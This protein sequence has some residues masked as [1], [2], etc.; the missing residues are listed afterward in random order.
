[1]HI[2]EANLLFGCCK[3]GTEAI[4][5]ILLDMSKIKDLELTPN[6][7]EKMYNLK[8][9][10]F[11]CSILHWNRVKLPEGLNF[12][13]DELRLLHWYEYPLESVPWSSCAE[14]L[15]EIGMVR[16]KLKQLWNGDQVGFSTL[17]Y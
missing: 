9:L 11:Y 4:K 5:G 13:P 8:F 2:F 14:N 6:A 3:Q 16:S 17:L 7:F 15:V 10:K 12:L 1:M